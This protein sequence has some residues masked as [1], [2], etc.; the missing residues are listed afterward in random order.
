M[1]Y[2]LIPTINSE[3]KIPWIVRF[4]TDLTQNYVGTLTFIFTEFMLIK[5]IIWSAKGLVECIK[6]EF[7]DEKEIEDD[8]Q[9]TD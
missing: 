5:I 8:N 3:I 9:R 1:C 4:I 7:I 6:E 2:L